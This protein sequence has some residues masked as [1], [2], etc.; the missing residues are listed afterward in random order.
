MDSP[1]GP[2]GGSVPEQPLRILQVNMEDAPGGAAQVAWSLHLAYLERGLQAWMEVGKKIRDDPKIYPLP[3]DDCRNQSARI[4][5][6][7]GNGFSP[8]VGKVRGFGRLRRWLQMVGQP[9]RVRDIRHGY[10]DFNFPGTWKL[11][12]LPPQRPGKGNPHPMRQPWRPTP[13]AS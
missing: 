10:E 8:L 11:L 12:D 7:I 13:S 1:G 5:F 2:R 4:W 9:Q 6:A 3:N